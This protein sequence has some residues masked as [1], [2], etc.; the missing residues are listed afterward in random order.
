MRVRPLLRL[1]LAVAAGKTTIDGSTVAFRDQADTTN[2]VLAE[3]TGSE[4]TIVTLDAA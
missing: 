4:R 3:M 2:R 1:L